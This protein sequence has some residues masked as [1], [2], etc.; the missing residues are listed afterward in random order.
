MHRLDPEGVRLRQRDPLAT[1]KTT[2]APHVD[3]LMAHVVT[4]WRRT[5]LELGMSRVLAS[6]SHELT[7]ALKRR[8]L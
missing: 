2:A 1:S 4:K 6:D 8:A 7:H 3:P 5:R